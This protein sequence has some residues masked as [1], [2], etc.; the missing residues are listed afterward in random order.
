MAPNTEDSRRTL[1]ELFRSAEQLGL[2]GV[3]VRAGNL[4]KRVGGYPQSNNRM[5]ICCGVMR[6]L[7]GPGDEIVQE[8]PSRDGASVTIR[9]RLPRK[10]R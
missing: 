5:P 2:V 9:Y 3:D 10:G 7:M 8:P 4:H 6:D 1:R